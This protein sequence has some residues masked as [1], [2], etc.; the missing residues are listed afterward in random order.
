MQC[1]NVVVHE[2]EFGSPVNHKSKCFQSPPFS[3][4]W[5]KLLFVQ[6]LRGW[7]CVSVTH[8][9]QVEQFKY[10]QSWENA[11]HSRFDYM[12]GDH[13]TDDKGWGH[14]QVYRRQTGQGS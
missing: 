2:F 1:M 13:V 4:H 10:L 3:F 6:Q 9:V 7:V 14:L 11:L 12:T 5:L 8:I